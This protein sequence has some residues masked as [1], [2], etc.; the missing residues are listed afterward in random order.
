MVSLL[1]APPGRT[2]GERLV[3]RQQLLPALTLAPS[4]ELARITL[5]LPCAEGD[6]SR[7]AGGRAFASRSVTARRIMSNR[8][9]PNFPVRW[10]MNERAR[11]ITASPAVDRIIP[12]GIG[13]LAR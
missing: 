2:P 7:A 1:H 13:R 10:I 3:S 12:P 11:S 8:T 5:S 6:T 4:L 9:A